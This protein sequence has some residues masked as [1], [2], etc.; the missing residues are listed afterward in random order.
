MAGTVVGRVAAIW[1][2]PVKSLQGESLEVSEVG[3][4]GLAGD[5]VYGVRDGLTGRV[6][7]AKREPLLLYSW[8]G[9]T[10]VQRW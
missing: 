8:P 2:Y 1:R 4:H 7:S 3:L 6:M 5:R 9:T 10:L